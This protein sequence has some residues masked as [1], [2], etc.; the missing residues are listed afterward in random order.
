M[1]KKRVFLLT[2][3]IL[4][5]LTTV[6]AIRCIRC[7]ATVD[8]TTS[9]TCNDPVDAER[10]ASLP[11]RDCPKDQVCG[12]LDG[13]LRNGQRAIV[14]DCYRQLYGATDG[15]YRHTCLDYYQETVDGVVSL[16][17]TDLCNVS[18]RSDPWL[19][20]FTALLVYFLF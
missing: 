1:A 6:S 8:G 11:V 2:S 7:R 13:L 20:S 3:A 19:F 17:S 12:K 15:T 10:V 14:R 5:T 18:S 16:C 4:V 9:N